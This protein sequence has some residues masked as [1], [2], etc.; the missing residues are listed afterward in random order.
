[1]KIRL[2]QIHDDP[3]LWQETLSIP[4]SEFE[5]SGVVKVS[6][7]ECE[8]RISRLEQGFFLQGE[9]RYGQTLL[10]D[11]CLNEVDD[12]VRERLEFLIQIG[13]PVPM[14]EEHELEEEELGLLRLE[15]DVLETDPL[16]LEQVR[17]N[18]PMK[19]LCRV[20]CKGLCPQCGTDLNREPCACRQHEID[21]RWA[22]LAA[23]RD[24]NEE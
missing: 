13:G 12:E 9:L 5:G 23:F 21:P 20:D 3:L 7:I 22:A 18:V 14:E 11:R 6:P 2:S 15:G 17:L 4:A 19:P 16:V 24:R 10:C 8:G 1:M